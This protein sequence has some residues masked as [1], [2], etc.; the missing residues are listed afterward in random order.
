MG[1]VRGLIG[2]W[3]T[4]T[5]SHSHL[6]T[7][8]SHQRI[9]P[10]P[11]GWA[12]HSG[13]KHSDAMK[14]VLMSARLS[15]WCISSHITDQVGGRSP[16]HSLS[17]SPFLVFVRGEASWTSHGRSQTLIVPNY[18]ADFSRPPPNPPS[19]VFLSFLQRFYPMFV[20]WCILTGP[21]HRGL[22]LRNGTQWHKWQQQL[23]Q[24]TQKWKNAKCNGDVVYVMITTVNNM[25]FIYSRWHGWTPANAIAMP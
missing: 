3:N 11:P 14:G 7:L 6:S 2:R 24:Y 19:V 18:K 22:T 25:H 21:T 4:P 20:G 9:W 12:H 5:V 15:P 23:W 1:A 8:Q 17:L 16:T 13:A 10:A